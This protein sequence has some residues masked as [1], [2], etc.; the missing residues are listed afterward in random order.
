M[1]SPPKILRPLAPLD[2]S[3]GVCEYVIF[4]QKLEKY[5]GTKCSVFKQYSSEHVKRVT[6]GPSVRRMAFVGHRAN[7][8]PSVFAAVKNIFL[9]LLRVDIKN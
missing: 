7:C 3:A 1:T 4:K 2:A 9:R 8:G 6:F 5:Y